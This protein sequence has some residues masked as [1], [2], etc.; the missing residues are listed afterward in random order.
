MT[1]TLRSALAVA[2]ILWC[3]GTGCI[4]VGYAHGAAMSAA[5]MTGAQSRKDSLSDASVMVSGHACCKSHHHASTRNGASSPESLPGLEQLALPE[6]PS[7]SG[8]N[9]CC[10]LTSGSFV[11]ASRAQTNDDGASASAQINS[12]I[13]SLSNAQTTLLAVPLRLPNQDQTYLR[14]CVFLI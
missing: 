11:A 6:G 9:S 13:P 3:A 14:C 5:D 1:A 2:L 12:D 10:P 7:P 4:I 8:A